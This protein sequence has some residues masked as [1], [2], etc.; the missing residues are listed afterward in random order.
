MDPRAETP[1]TR[2]PTVRRCVH[3]AQGRVF[4]IDVV[5]VEMDSGRGP[6]TRVFVAYMHLTH[7]ARG[8]GVRC[9]S[10]PREVY[11]VTE[12][13]ALRNARGILDAGAFRLEADDVPATP[14]NG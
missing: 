2:P 5:P 12:D 1:S 13:W 8:T 4:E 10:G 3:H 6:A 14:Q 11:G 9:T 7:D